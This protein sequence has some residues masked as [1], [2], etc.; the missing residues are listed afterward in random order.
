[1]SGLPTLPTGH[2]RINFSN[3]ETTPQMKFYKVVGFVYYL[4]MSVYI[5]FV[6]YLDMSV[7]IKFVIIVTA[8]VLSVIQTDVLK[9][10][11]ILFSINIRI[12]LEDP[13]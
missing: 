4:D 12:W 2:F 11:K 7:Y 9:M 10:A 5:K 8:I 1:M 3:Q 6:Y 13:Q